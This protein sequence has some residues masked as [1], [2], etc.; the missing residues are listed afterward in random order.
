M[1]VQAVII[2]KEKRVVYKYML[3]KLQVEQ[4]EL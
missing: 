2:A 1:T 3:M 4:T